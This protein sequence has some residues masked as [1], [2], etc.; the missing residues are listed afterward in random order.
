MSLK[1]LQRRAREARHWLGARALPLW[2]E[3]GSLRGEGGFVSALEL[4]H[5]PASDV[6]LADAAGQH[7]LIALFRLAPEVGYDAEIAAARIEAALETAGDVAPVMPPPPT[8]TTRRL[9]RV[10]DQLRTRVI[11]FASGQGEDAI[12]GAKAA[13][14]TFDRLMDEFLTPEG[15]WIMGYDA[16]GLLTVQDIPAIGA[17]PVA[18]ALGPLVAL[19][20]A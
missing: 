15:G 14:R 10:C 17:A 7:A 6:G 8:D 11:S 4:N 3:A 20:E 12:L 2:S 16:A 19:L 1:A 18:A 9:E 13:S 5:R